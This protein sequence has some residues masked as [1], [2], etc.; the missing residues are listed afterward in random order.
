M[1]AV[2]GMGRSPKIVG[3]AISVLCVVVFPLNILESLKVATFITGTI[4]NGI[5]ALTVLTMMA[6]GAIYAYKLT[7]MMASMGGSS[8]NVI[9]KIR[10]VCTSH[11]KSE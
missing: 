11:T 6:C 4:S 5:F 1:K 2:K 10:K 7:N 9:S 3:A 8:K